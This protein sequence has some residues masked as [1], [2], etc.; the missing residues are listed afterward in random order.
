V[1]L[2]NRLWQQS[3]HQR[4]GGAIEAA[5][6][7]GLVLAE[8]GLSARLVATG[9]INGRQVQLEWRGGFL[10]ARSRLAV[11]GEGRWGA[12]IADAGALEAALRDR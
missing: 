6:L 9:M 1:Y 8:P 11:D 7:R 12:L 10:G 5:A 4:A 2:F 3:L